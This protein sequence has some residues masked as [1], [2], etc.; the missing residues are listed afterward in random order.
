[1]PLEWGYFNPLQEFFFEMGFFK[2]GKKRGSQITPICN[3][4]NKPLKNKIYKPKAL[5]RF[6]SDKIAEMVFKKNGK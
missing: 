2:D 5:L 6:T 1:M 3:W 4:F